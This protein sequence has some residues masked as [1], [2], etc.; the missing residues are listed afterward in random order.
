MSKTIKK[1]WRCVQEFAEYLAEKCLEVNIETW[2]YGKWV[3]GY[4]FDIDL[5]TKFWAEVV[6]PYLQDIRLRAPSWE[7]SWTTRKDPNS[8][9]A[10]K[11]FVIMKSRTHLDH[12]PV[13]HA[14]VYDSIERFL[15]AFS[16]KMFVMGTDPGFSKD[17]LLTDIVTEPGSNVKNGDVIPYSGSKAVVMEVHDN[18]AS[19]TIR[20]L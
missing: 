18:A 9:Y 4:R 13:E 3:G 15:E 12:I 19:A 7:I 11:K 8:P 6:V 5:E 10:K 1:H 20:L 2:K 17:V 16:P 14:G